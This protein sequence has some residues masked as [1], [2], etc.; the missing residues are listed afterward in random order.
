MP[1]EKTKEPK[2]Y[3]RERK[4]LKQKLGLKKKP[5]GPGRIKTKHLQRSGIPISKLE[6]DGANIIGKTNDAL[7]GM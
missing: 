2:K 1:K 4:S 6:K 7:F 3:K 5:N